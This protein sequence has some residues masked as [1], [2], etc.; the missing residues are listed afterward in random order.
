MEMPVHFGIDFLTGARAKNFRV[1]NNPTTPNNLNHTGRIW[2]QED[3]DALFYTRTEGGI[4]VP[5]KLLDDSPKWA[6]L[7]GNITAGK[8]VG[9]D[10][11]TWTTFIDDFEAMKF[12]S[13]KDQTVQ[14]L[15]HI[16][17][18]YLMGSDMFPHIHWVCTDNTVGTVRWKV[19][20]I[21]AK[22]HG[23]TVFSN[24][25]TI[26]IEEDTT[27]LANTHFVAESDIGWSHPN[28]EPDAVVV[29]R[30]TRE[31]TH[32]ND[33]A[34]GNIFALTADLHY[35]MGDTGTVGKRPDFYIPD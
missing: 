19:E 24:A 9:V 12:A 33:S 8:G 17:H 4:L 21:I 30:V 35:Q 3:E 13:N 20:L 32:P 29:A 28:M 5:R 11:P 27:G 16:N 1:F 7:F 2:Y 26:I 22:G 25:E 18:D 14:L 31:A 15:Y 6:D 34:G 10:A 23:Q